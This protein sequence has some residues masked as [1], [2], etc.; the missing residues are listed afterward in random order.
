MKA[1]AEANGVE[2]P[3]GPG[4]LDALVAHLKKRSKAANDGS[5]KTPRKSSAKSRMQRLGCPGDVQSKMQELGR[6]THL[7][8]ATHRRKGWLDHRYTWEVNYNFPVMFIVQRRDGKPRTNT[9]MRIDPRLRFALH[10]HARR[11]Y[12]SLSTVSEQLLTA[13]FLG[14]KT[15][16]ARFAMP[17]LNRLWDDRPWV[18]LRN[19]HGYDKGLLS[20]DE[21]QVLKEMNAAKLRE[22]T[23]EQ[24]AE[25]VEDRNVEI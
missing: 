9:S 10:L 18:R 23:P 20:R 6:L 22:V 2:Y 7:R 15:E 21:Q 5:A 17:E 19:V 12:A 16:L 25:L 24:W 4:S 1:W 14:N 11:G 8:T 13:V 3:K